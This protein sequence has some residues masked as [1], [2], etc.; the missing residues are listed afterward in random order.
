MVTVKFYRQIKN[1]LIGVS[2]VLMMFGVVLQ[3]IILRYDTQN[4][5]AQSEYESALEEYVENNIY[6]S[7]DDIVQYV[8]VRQNPSGYFVLNPDLIFEPSEYNPSTL[9]ATRFSVVTLSVLNQSRATNRD[10][11]VNYVMSNYENYSTPEGNFTGFSKYE[12]Y[13]SGVRSTC[14]ALMTLEA[15]DALD[16]PFLDLNSIEQ[17]ILYHQNSD[18]GFWDDDYPHYG[19]N[20]TLLA[21]SFAIRSLGR[22]YQFQG[23]EFNETLKEAITEFIIDCF[24]ESDGGYANEPGTGSTDSYGI[25]RAF[26]SLWWLGGNNDTSRRSNVEQTMDLESTVSYVYNHLYDNETG[27][28]Y[29]D[30]VDGLGQVS[31]KSTHLMIWFLDALNRDWMLNAS[32]LGQYLMSQLVTPGQ[33]GPDI[34]STYAAALAFERLGISTE[35]LP[36]PTQ[37]TLVSLEY[38]GIFP[39]MMLSLGVISMVSAYYVQHNTIKAEQSVS[40]YLERE[41]EKRTQDLQ[42][43]IRNHEKTRDDLRESERRY[44]RLFED[45]PLSLWVEDYSGANE[46]LDDLVSSGVTDLRTHLSKNEDALWRCADAVQILD[47]NRATL[48]L[49]GLTDKKEILGPVRQVLNRDSLPVFLDQILALHS[50]Q[51]SYESEVEELFVSG[52]NKALI[53]K[54]SVLAESED[55]LSRVL[56]TMIDITERK[57]AEEYVAASLAEKELLLKE[58]HHRVKNN[59]QIISS[60]L[61]LQ[62]SR[63]RDSETALALKE[64]EQR[65]KSMAMIHEALYRSDDL[66]QIDFERYIHDLVRNILVSFGST[67]NKVSLNVNIRERYLD[68]AIAIPCALIIN[69][70]VSNSVKHA[71]PDNRQGEI[72][73]SLLA[74]NEDTLELCVSDNGIGVPDDFHLNESESLGLKLVTRLVEMQLNGTLSLERNEKTEYLIRFKKGD[75]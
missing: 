29:L 36:V 41:V 38:L 5:M 14:D 35:P 15:L 42:I 13:G 72:E 59:M 58:I 62:S 27:A 26:I 71:F 7:P 23:R 55:T 37:P 61:H 57:R 31:L 1:Y 64:S 50:G 44:R 21:T 20:S 34:Y 3:A 28:F 60:L 39:F 73:I 17:F 18:G 6:Y 52:E 63:I 56:L 4:Q 54:L 70:L 24:D 19:M 10:T 48:S 45:S 25:F 11:T 74:I 65:V 40:E 2:L 68:I 33:Y 51:S 43:E 16:T 49:H 53:L 30:E 32:A 12:G 8:R 69:E 67:S 47:V 22:I 46:I 66:A 9:R 75:V